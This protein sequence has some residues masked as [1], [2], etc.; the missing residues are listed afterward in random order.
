MF[1]CDLAAV[2]AVKREKSYKSV[3]GSISEEIRELERV[4]LTVESD[5]FLSGDGHSLKIRRDGDWLFFEGEEGWA[6][7]FSIRAI[8]DE[9]VFGGGEQ[10]RK[11]NLR[12]ETVRNLVTEHVKVST[13]IEKALLPAKMYKPKEFSDIGTYAPMPLFVTDTGRMFLFDTSSDG[14][15]FFGDDVYVFSFDSCPSG[16]LLCSG[17]SYKELALKL[18]QVY[19][20]RQYIPDW[21]LDGMIIGAQGGE[22]A[23]LEKTFRLLDAGAKICGVWSQDWSGCNETVMGYQVWWNWAADR[24][25]YPHLEDTIKKLNSRGVRFLSYINPY[26]VKGSGIYN[27]CKNN[28]YLILKAD[29]SIYHVKSTTFEAGMLDLTNPAA[30]HYIKE[31]L[32]KR[33][34]LD[35]G[36]SGWMAD[37][38]EYLPMDCVLHDG[39]PAELHNLWPVMWAKINREA[40]D[41]YGK[42]D[43]FFF[44]RSGYLGVQQYAPVMWNGDQHTDFTQDYGLPSVMPASFS[45][46]FSG[47]TMLHCDAGGFF[48]FMKLKR[49]PEV[50]K[51]WMQM[52]AFSLMMRSHESIRP[53]ANTQPYDEEVLAETVKQTKI[54]AE[55]KPYL[56]HCL[57]EAATGV[58]QLRPDFWAD[59]KCGE[60]HS[61]YT[62]FLGD[63]LFVCPVFEKGS[64]KMNV[65]LPDGDWVNFWDGRKCEGGKCITVSTPAGFIPVFYRKGSKYKSVFKK[66]AGLK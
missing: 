32:I 29:R 30:V 36:V 15:A 28:G 16:L 3:R 34:M 13:L 59:M 54:H 49:D 62:Y 57:K 56:Q 35:L 6:Y 9:A 26:L 65:W 17:K 33:N 5:G 45:L 52:C 41:E 64:K 66:A 22:D 7:E 31:V 27:Y 21:C 14:T 2:T 23:I 63:D 20:N 60:N 50:L 38:G 53:D 51:R 4:P 37:F 42:K 39:D 8:P 43:V 58:P 18:A 10:Y 11:L 47:V 24:N 44:S 12:G 25:L 55:L 46:G 1:N 40:I 48:S 61:D 19:P